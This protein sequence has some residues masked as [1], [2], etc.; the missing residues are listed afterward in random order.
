MVIVIASCCW[1]TTNTLTIHIML[2]QASSTRSAW[3]RARRTQVDG[4][5]M[6]STPPA[7][8]ARPPMV[9]AA[10]ALTNARRRASRPSRVWWW[11]GARSCRRRR[12]PALRPRRPRPARR[13]LVRRLCQCA[14]M[15]ARNAAASG[16]APTKSM[17][18]A[19]MT[20]PLRQG[21]ASRASRPS[22]VSW[23]ASAC[24][25]QTCP[26]ARTPPSPTC[27]RVS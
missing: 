4:A 26:C 14:R 18:L 6:W 5:A 23:M 3:L 8:P 19:V 12:G 10:R 13:R 16:E 24:I 27:V 20:L 15:I 7:R 17:E 2:H 9:A 22:R 25:P 1:G 11:I 21:A